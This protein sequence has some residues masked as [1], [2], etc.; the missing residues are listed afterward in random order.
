MKRLLVVLLA[1]VAVGSL[2]GNVLLYRRYS[3]NRPVV[4]LGDDS[5]VL[6]DYRDM[7]DVQAGRQV[8]TKM[9]L[10]KIVMNAAKKAGVVPTK[11]D[12]DRRL[13]FIYRRNPQALTA[14]NQDPVKMRLL[15]EDMETDIALESLTIKDVKV[16]DA[17]VM[18][19]YRKNAAAF[20][21]P[22]QSQAMMA[23]AS[24]A[25]DASTAQRMMLTKDSKGN[26]TIDAGTLARQPRIKVVGINTNLN[27]QALPQDLQKDIQTRVAQLKA[28]SV[29]TVRLPVKE[30]PSF[31]IVRVERNAPAGVPALGDIKT[32]VE[33]ACRLA[34]TQAQGGTVGTLVRLYREA[35]PR[36]E[37]TQYASYFENMAVLEKQLAGLKAKGAK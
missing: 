27:F 5:V 28:G 13:A 18:A 12:V 6:K 31:L 7:L 20:T 30:G 4:W 10:R 21:A 37:M 14:A 35:N 16:S 24:N 34:K 26:L 2:L 32:E 8:L 1:L 19:F 9:V 29:F 17:E 36:F 11:D 25:V 33:R 23:L 22:Q 3:T 15:R